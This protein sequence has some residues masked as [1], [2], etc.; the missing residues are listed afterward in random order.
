MD[1]LLPMQECL[2]T[3]FFLTASR[4]R[5]LQFVKSIL[6]AA[7]MIP[8]LPSEPVGY[9]SNSSYLKD[10]TQLGLFQ[11]L[12]DEDE[13]S[14]DDICEKVSSDRFIVLAIT[15]AKEANERVEVILT[16]TLWGGGGEG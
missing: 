11:S 5:L 6:I 8:L 2:E 10:I 7:S 13:A 3:A 12:T 4:G 14:S 16:Q 9:A 1:T 15:F